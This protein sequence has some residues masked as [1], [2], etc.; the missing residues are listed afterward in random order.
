VEFHRFLVYERPKTI[1]YTLSAAWY[2]GLDT[3][4]EYQNIAAPFEEYAT[5]RAHLDYANLRRTIGAVDVERGFKWS[6]GAAASVVESEFFPQV[7]ASADYGFLLPIEHSSIWLRGAAGKSWGDRENAFANFYFGAFGNNWVD[8]REA[9]RYREFD[10]FPGLEL[11]E[12]GAN[13]F[14]KAT[15]EWSLPPLKFRRAGVPSFYTNWARLSLFSSALVTDPAESEFRRD[16]YNAG[17]QVDLSVVLFTSLESMISV[18]YARAFD[19]DRQADEVMLS[20]KLLR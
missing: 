14:T 11:N 3:L 1:D 17:A 15:V 19:G 4:P 18:G 16:L 20:L 6:A 5:V 9:Q 2:G 12:A 10:S 8:W 13:D 7:L